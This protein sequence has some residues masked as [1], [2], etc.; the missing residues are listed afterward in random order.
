MRPD[1]VCL[2][3]SWLN[4]SIDDSLVRLKN[5][6]IA[7]SDRAKKKGGGVAIYLRDDIPFKEDTV[8]HMFNNE[9][10]CLFVDLFS[11]KIGVLCIYI[12]PH[13]SAS[14]LSM[15]HENM[16][17]LL[18]NYL[19]K[20]PKNRIIVLGDFNHFKVDDFCN[21]NNM[22]DIISKPTRGPNI[23]DH[24]L[25]D[26]ALTTVYSS[27]K[28][29]FLP[30][31]GKSDHLTLFIAAENGRETAN[32][33]H[34]TI[35]DFRKSHLN[36]LFACASCLDW[37]PTTSIHD[38]VDSQWSVLHNQIMIL[39][40]QTIPQTLVKMTSND[41][42]WMTPLTK[43]LLNE[44]WK[45]F[46]AQDWP[47]FHFLKEKT[48]S[49]IIKAKSLWAQ[50]LKSSNFGLWKLVRGVSGKA[51]DG[52]LKSLVEEYGSPSEL[53][54]EI[55]SRV[56]V[57]E[58][59][60]SESTTFL[61]ADDG[62]TILATQWDVERRLQRLSPQKAAGVD[63]I[64][65]RVYT[66]LAPFISVPLA[67]LFNSSIYQRKFPSA[68][69][70]SIM[71]PIPK[72]KRPSIDKLRT[73]SLLPVPSKIF[74]QT[75]LRAVSTELQ[76]TFGTNQHGFRPKASCT[77]ALIQM[78]ETSTR[79][80]DDK[81][82]KGYAI[83]SMDLSKAF[84]RVHHYTLLAK[85]HRKGVSSGFLNWLTSYLTDREFKVRIQA[86]C[87]SPRKMTTGVPQGSVLGPSLFCALV[88]DLPD[89]IAGSQVVQYADDV[90]VIFGFRTSSALEVK[91]KIENV[92][93]A[94]EQWCLVNKQTLNRSKSSLLINMR[95]Y[96]LLHENLSFSVPVKE[97]LKVLGV[98][99][100]RKLTWDDHVEDMCLRASRRLYVLRRMK[101]LVTETEL[102]DI[103]KVFIRS[104]F[105]YCCPAFVKLNV[106][107]SSRMQRVE[108]RAHRI[109]YGENITCNCGSN[110]LQ[111]RREENSVKLLE[112]IIADEKHPLRSLIP[113]QLANS[114]K[115]SNFPCRTDK[116]KYS[117]FPFTTLLIN[118]DSHI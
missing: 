85:L 61:D 55:A 113:E 19:C 45:A 98:T 20:F 33:R 96:Q 11:V 52:N 25:I 73:I 70:K 71:V 14:S 35:F 28:V 43:H 67:H 30:P 4:A 51:N 58:D 59:V 79:H 99:I 36:R 39:L 6:S 27:A 49:E 90:N 77:T 65:N 12:P 93:S 57:S 115:L 100:N 63:G 84:D 31:I 107:F 46:R 105:E 37:T 103:Y 48:A 44:K 40:D 112:T 17:T 2:T 89:A 78:L 75:V 8:S 74:E 69:K 32:T 66:L 54:E 117:F 41:K 3:E 83:L 9:V 104:V 95:S 53:A 22:K 5:Y 68:W 108:N 24:V 62:W 23:L 91:A 18:D 101:R 13:L 47:K 86:T 34:H 72:T 26:H 38:D 92:I 1:L 10:E 88:G 60:F 97:K 76:E 106:K 80:H 118:S 16:T 15:V 21:E 110:S 111:R 87:S 7:R 81:T 29:D 56:I 64:P 42:E 82:I 109:I 50:K 116:R 102:H 114:G 94:V